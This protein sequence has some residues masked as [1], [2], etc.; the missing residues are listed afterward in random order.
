MVLVVARCGRWEEEER[1]VELCDEA[2]K[3]KNKRGK[4]EEE[5]DVSE[6]GCSTAMLHCYCTTQSIPPSWR[7]GRRRRSSSGKTKK[8]SVT[9][10]AAGRAV[11]ALERLQRRR[12]GSKEEMQRT[13]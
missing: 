13:W 10:R 7:R 11:V 8:K 2:L 6:N 12:Q 1:G 9:K 5:Q 3:K 4:D